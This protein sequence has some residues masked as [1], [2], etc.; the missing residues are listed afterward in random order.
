M[1][2]LCRAFHALCL[3]AALLAGS[4]HAQN[5]T[6]RNVVIGGG[7][8]VSGLLYHP[9][10][11]DVLYARTDVG[12]VYR[13]QP[14]TQRWLPL[15]DALG[16]N[17]S[18]LTGVVSFAVD[19]NDA[20]RL[21][22]ACGQYLPSW[23]Q[24]GAVLSSTDQGATWSR[25]D[26]PIK[27]GGNSD[28][29][30]TGERLQ[31]DPNAGAILFL[32]T[33]QD[34]LWKS[35]DRARTWTRVAG[36]APT[37]VTA[38]VFDP[39]SGTSGNPT[40]TLYAATDATAAASLYRSTDGGTTW[41]AVAGAPAGLIVHHA[42]L[43]S[44][45]ILYLAYGNGLGP[46]GVTSGAVW[47]LR[48]SDGTWTN[49]TPPAGQGGF[50]GL[51]LDA[52]HPGTL[53]VTTLDRWWP[54]DQIYR[55][56][57]GGTNWKA[58]NDPQNAS[59]DLSNW[60]YSF[61]PYTANSTPHWLG[62]FE[63][64]PFDGNQAWFVTGYGVF[65]T[66]NLTVV[67][68]NA[69]LTW[70]FWDNGLEET[71][72]L[73]LVSP[74]SGAPLVSVVG[75]QDGFRHD[76]LDVAPA[77]GR[78]SPTVGTNNSIDFAESV[79][80]QM[81]RTHGGGASRGSRSTDGGATWTFFASN[82]APATTDRQGNIAISA[83]A[84]RLVWAP[85]DAALYY[86]I[87][88]GATWTAATGG[89][90]AT[91]GRTYVPVSDRVNATKFYV[92][93][94]AGRV[95]VSTN[96]GSSFAVAASAVPTT[97]DLLRAVPGREGHLWLAAA[98][99]GLY[100][101]TDSGATFA[102]VATVDQ[103]YRVGFGRNAPGRDYPAVYVSA[104][105]GGVTGLFRSDDNA[106]TWVRINDDAHQFGWL[107]VIT[108]D[109][110]VYGRVYLA[111]G[112][113]G[114]IYGSAGAITPAIRWPTPAPLRA[115][116]ALSAAELGASTEVPGTFT[117]DPPPGTVL[118]VGTHTLTV[119]FTP[120]DPTVYTTAT[121]QVAVTVLAADDNT[122]PARLVNLSARAYCTSG[123]RVA[124]GGFVVGGDVPKRVLLRAVGPSL[125]AQGLAAGEL[126]SDPV[127]EVHDATRGG[128]A[129]RN[130]DWGQN[131]NAAEITTVAARVG[132]QPLLAGDTRSAAMLATLS[133]GI[134]TFVVQGNDG[135][136]GIVLL[137]VY[138]ADAVTSS[139][140]F[141]NIATRA[142]ASGGNRVA[143][144]GFVITGTAAKR[145]LVRAVGPTL[146]TQGLDQTEVLA[147]PTIE[148]HWYNHG[149]V[150]VNDDWQ[151]DENATQVP[152]TA[153]RIGATALAQNDTKSAAMLRT[154]QPGVYTFLAAGAAN[155]SGIV[156]IEVYD[157]D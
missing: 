135:G 136:S 149:V 56:T 80:G 120:T 21:Y 44:D 106:A 14:A 52:Q 25:V 139:T 32:G 121:A 59:S 115:G 2:T 108:G 7:G 58:L 93:D 104:R 156:L 117:Y 129:A 111:T 107:N 70:H 126:L 3:T 65:G 48:T 30:S 155:T 26:L 141:V 20:S 64:N 5:Y 36:F 1:P 28:G 118:P 109:A 60:D 68:T 132:A 137:E 42:K 85:S 79:P 131:D 16:R 122:R 130:N 154:L 153:A 31:V 146:A 19:P 50:A 91:S 100:R 15:N 73:G 77:R 148:L 53:V 40:P 82:P 124:I 96:G 17:E 75:D 151:N 34:G 157:A 71:V 43:S 125:T 13:W 119:T 39:R 61:A 46:N 51:A 35:T 89:P 33:N 99:N 150:G 92:Y 110:R 81:V 84:A 145:V 49:I 18:Q 41:T 57:D 134:Y 94:P 147:D 37:G 140:V 113:R 9:T 55:S 6:W 72:P 152:A 22:L 78:H 95:F 63:I 12:G 8:F 66:D 127:F 90:A 116:T 11:R 67:D 69:A 98:A 27:L 114:I 102:R 62:A 4:V 144:G 74:P 29:R 133:P 128:I 88:A 83:D 45:G 86:S 101:S 142:Y 103:A 24:A 138:D 143:I 105:I 47:K 38:V 87:D 123:N 76:D 10:Q 23:A 54:G 112:G 97:G